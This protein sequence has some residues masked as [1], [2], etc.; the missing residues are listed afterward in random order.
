MLIDPFGLR[1]GQPGSV[2]SFIPVW[3]SA[4]SAVDDFQC[5]K[6]G[7]GLFNAGMAGLDLVGGW[8]IKAGGRLAIKAG[9]HAWRA[10]RKWLGKEVWNL[11]KGTQVH[12]WLVPQRLYDGIE[13]Q[14]VREITRAIFNQPWNLLPVLPRNG[15][16]SQMLH[17][18][19]HGKGPLAYGPIG[20]LWYGTPHEAKA[21][22]GM[23]AGDVPNSMTIGAADECE[24]N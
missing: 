22:V 4:R 13:N 11:P 17:N 15:I 1:V 8:L 6:W 14:T 5:G 20:R 19:I 2:E 24:C 18:G 9:S 12:H 10:T 21:V 23:V 16:T 3:G 7:R